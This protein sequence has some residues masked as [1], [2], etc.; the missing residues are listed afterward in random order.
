MNTIDALKTYAGK[1]YVYLVSRGNKAIK[2]ALK[3]AK[4]KGKT[5]VLIPE[6]GGWLVYE[7]YPTE[8]KMKLKRIKCRNAILDLSY[9]KEELGRDAVLLVNSMPAYSTFEQ[10]ELLVN[11]CARYGAM[12]INDA[13]GSVGTVHARYGDVIV[14][15]FG[16]W[17]PIE[18]GTGGFIA[19]NEAFHVEEAN[20]DE[21][22]LSK[23][24]KERPE[25]TKRWSERVKKIKRDL[26][27]L[28]VVHPESNGYVAIIKYKNESEKHQITLYCAD[29]DLVFTECP[30]YIRLQQPA[31][32][33]EV[34]QDG[35]I[36]D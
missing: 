15:S 36:E 4:E 30:R 27:S 1:N 17:K 34:K 23:A 33:I 11:V 29:H 20:I 35:K 25:K 2:E 6:E 19:S 16:R 3:F 21:L 5:K 12:I 10:M 8:L 28:N 24:I 32:S 13:S 18:M 7:Q 31:I 26:S 22:E 14:C 9:L